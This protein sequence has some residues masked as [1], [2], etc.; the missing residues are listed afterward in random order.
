M[1]PHCLFIELSSANEAAEA[2]HYP[3]PAPRVVGCQIETGMFD[4]S[5]EELS[6]IV[7]WAARE[8]TAI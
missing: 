3:V 7:E 2:R 6:R 5:D 8:R 4:Y 1:R